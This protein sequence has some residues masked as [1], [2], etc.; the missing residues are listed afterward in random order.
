MDRRL[1][2]LV[3]ACSLVALII[4]IGLWARSGDSL[5]LH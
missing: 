4:V 1:S 5:W 3:G 2:L